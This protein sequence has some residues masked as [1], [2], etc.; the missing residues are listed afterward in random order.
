MD[1][2]NLR[3]QTR[4]QRRA[5]GQARQAI[6][7]R[8]LDK[9]LQ[10]F[11]ITANARY[12]GLY[13]VNDGEIDP[14]RFMRWAFTQAKHCYLPVLDKQKDQP[15]KFAEITPD[16]HFKPN[17]FGIPEPVVQTPNLLD[18]SELDLLL[19]PLVA[20]DFKGNRIGMGGG[21]YDRTLAFTRQRPYD[22]RPKL[23]GL[24]HEFQYCEVIEPSAWDIPLDGIATEKQAILFEL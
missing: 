15:M 10:Q 2:K 19:M 21:Y 8:L 16:S 4:Q 22:K 6:A 11:S 7:A 14:A 12:I 5:L 3:Q 1:I 24:A 18:A 17:R 9:Q 13:L 23:I 20:F